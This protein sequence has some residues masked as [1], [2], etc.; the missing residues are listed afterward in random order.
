ML[1]AEHPERPAVLTCETCGSFACIACGVSTPWGPSCCVRCAAAG[2]RG[3]PIPRES[4]GGMFATYRL[5][6]R[7]PRT[8]FGSLREGSI[9]RALSFAV[10]QQIVWSTVFQ[11]LR[12]FTRNLRGFPFTS[13]EAFAAAVIWFGFLAYGVAVCAAAGVT[14]SAL[15]GSG[16][17]STRDC[18]RAALYTSPTPVIAAV[19]V[20]LTPGPVWW[21]LFGLVTAFLMARPLSYFAQG[22]GQATAT[23][24]SASAFVAAALGIFGLGAPLAWLLYL[25]R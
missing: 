6:G 16:R 19:G 4:K 15:L 2:R 5:A 24:G 10:A 25:V 1:C 20:G 21:L 3:P 9:W 12:V 18:V 22:R 7:E 8:F 14:L 13:G 17:V 23:T 11:A